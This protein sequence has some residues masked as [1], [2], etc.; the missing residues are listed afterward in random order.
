MTHSA[1]KL[2][3][4]SVTFLDNI[5]IAEMNEGILFD[6][7]HNKELLE[8]ASERFGKQPYGYISNRVNSYSVNPMIHL[9]SASI[10]NLMA[11]AVVSKNPVVKQNSII[12]KQ[13]FRNSS[14]FEVF[15]TL[16]EAINWIK[17]QLV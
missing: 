5:Q 4:G 15:E 11:I 2:D 1:L 10:S 6:V 12:E 9:D 8:L 14:S 3:F 17:H 13:F 7:P 16:E